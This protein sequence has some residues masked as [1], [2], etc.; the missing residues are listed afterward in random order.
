MMKLLV[1][2][3]PVLVLLLGCASP[4]KVV[5]DPQPSQAAPLHPAQLAGPEIEQPKVG[6]HLDITVVK[7]GDKALLRVGIYRHWLP[8]KKGRRLVWTYVTEGLFDKQQRELVLTLDDGGQPQ[9][10][11]FH[12]SPLSYFKAVYELAAAGKLVGPGGQTHF[13][14]PIPLGGS[15][16]GGIIYTPAEELEGV[17]LPPHALA[18]IP[19]LPLEVTAAEMFGHSRVLFRLGN[20]HR[21]YPY[22]VWHELGRPSVI[23]QAML[24]QTLLN[25]APRLHAQ[26]MGV[27]RQPKRIILRLVKDER[28]IVSTALGSLDPKYPITFLTAPD[29]AANGCLV[30]VPGSQSPSAIIPEGSHGDDLC[31]AFLIIAPEQKDEQLRI[32]EDGY[33]LLLSTPDW[34]QLRRALMDGQALVLPAQGDRPEVILEIIEPTLPK[35]SAKNHLLRPVGVLS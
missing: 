15:Q 1:G 28:T 21:Q 26:A 32:I 9:Q 34:E 25:K 23:D 12:L 5:P 18:A 22:P 11:S 35:G 24:D 6:S 4:Q 7:E 3:V 30:W 27:R 19:L 31:G 8:T 2:C 14:T 29:P 16:V 13:H 10:A 20:Y 17:T 33:G